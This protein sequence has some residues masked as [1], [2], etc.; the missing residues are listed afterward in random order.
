[1]R[2]LLF[3]WKIFEWVSSLKINKNKMELYYLGS[4]PRKADRLANIFGCR[5]GNLPF[6]YLG[7][8]L[9]NKL[10]RKED[11]ALVINRIEARI[12][13]WMAKLLSQGGRL[14]LVNSVPTNLPL[15][16]LSIFKAPHWVLHRIEALRRAFFWKG[17][18]KIFD[19]AC[20]IS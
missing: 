16:Y 18:S 11:W 10:L 14:I 3:L 5:A 15:F 7:L 9:Y 1:M 4:N 19:G 8:P 2:N 13:R 17:C 20:L 6:R 12:E